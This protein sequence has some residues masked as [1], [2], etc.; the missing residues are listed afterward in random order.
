[1]VGR[2]QLIRTFIMDGNFSAEHM[3]SRTREKDISLSDGMAFM[4][5][6]SSYM[7]HLKTGKEFTQVCD[8]L[9]ISELTSQSYS[10]VHATHTRPLNKHLLGDLILMS[11][12]SGRPP[13]AMASLFLHLWWTFRKGRGMSH[14]L[15]IL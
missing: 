13:A 5:N 6:Q 2:N 11:Q 7:A 12:A 10:L 9:S 15:A 14:L 1:M 3:K 4:V 8:W